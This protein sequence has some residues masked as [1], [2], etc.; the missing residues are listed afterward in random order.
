MLEE[1]SSW[2][3]CSKSCS[4]GFR[5]RTRNILKQA[6]GGGLPC[7]ESHDYQ[8]CTSTGHCPGAKIV[9]ETGSKSLLHTSTSVDCKLTEWTGWSLCTKT[10]GGGTQKKTRS[11]LKQE[12]FGGQACPKLHETNEC[13][14]K[15]CPGKFNCQSNNCLTTSSL[16]QLTANWLNGP[17]GVHA[18]KSAVEEL[19]LE[20]GVFSHNNN[21]R[22]NL[23]Q[24]FTRHT[25]AIQK[26]VQVY[27]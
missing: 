23:A 5:G 15:E 27:K 13:N 24:N 10:C 11:V 12:Q 22:E 26:N 20:E 2:S 19:K 16:F 21:M 4:E 25:S 1:W 18:L 17:V 3:S 7:G 8:R 14:T 9:R 6:E